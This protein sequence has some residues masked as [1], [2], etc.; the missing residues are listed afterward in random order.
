MN[1]ILDKEKQHDDLSIRPS[2]I[3]EYIGQEKII[4]GL[5]IFL[6][7]STLRNEQLDNNLLYAPPAS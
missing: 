1:K 5:K 7:P 2:K 4:Q 6:K 3:D